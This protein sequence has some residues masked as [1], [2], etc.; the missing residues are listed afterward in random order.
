MNS[1]AAPSRSAFS[2]RDPFGPVNTLRFITAQTTKTT[3]VWVADQTNLEFTAKVTVT[4]VESALRW[5]SVGYNPGGLTLSEDVSCQLSER[6][7]VKCA[8]THTEISG[9]RTTSSQDTTTT[10]DSIIAS[11]TP[12][13]VEN[14]SLRPV[15]IRSATPTTTSDS[16]TPTF[17]PT[18]KSIDSFWYAAIKSSRYW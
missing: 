10:W 15:V 4:D 7:F 18:S 3:T 13:W 12:L 2:I 8:A 16:F 14:G 5:Q 1:T 9:A 17:K 6:A 11:V